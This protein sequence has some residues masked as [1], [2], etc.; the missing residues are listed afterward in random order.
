M[1]RYFFLWIVMVPIFVISGCGVFRYLDGSSDEEMRK[2]SV[3][4]KELQNE[5]TSLQSGHNA[6]RE[7]VE[8]Q[9][10]ELDRFEEREKAR[11]K[12]VSDRQARVEILEK[13]KKTLLE[14]NE[15]L[16]TVAAPKE[17][18]LTEK[19]AREKA[20]VAAVKEPRIK[21]LTGTGKI[22]VA[23]VLSKKLRSMGYKVERMARAPTPYFSSNTV[24]FAKDSE[25]AAREL[26]GRLGEKTV[27]KPL[28]WPSIFDIIVVAGRK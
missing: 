1:K 17:E 16:K 14:E 27:V 11:L 18:A 8:K 6:L 7:T 4:R 10:A 5:V 2:F 13:E 21:V 3:S 28:T 19:Q 9:Q 24:F 25:K 26:A 12:A 22:S 15:K 20:Q 23:R